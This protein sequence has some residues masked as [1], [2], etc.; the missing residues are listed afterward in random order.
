MLGKDIRSVWE[1]W[2]EMRFRLDVQRASHREDDS[3][4]KTCIG[5]GTG[6]IYL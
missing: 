2:V 6:S 3:C 5:E 4:V 1:E